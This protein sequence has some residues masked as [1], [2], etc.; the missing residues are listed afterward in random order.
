M[1]ADSLTELS[2]NGRVLVTPCFGR[3]SQLRRSCA[4]ASIQTGVNDARRVCRRQ[5]IH[6]ESLGTGQETSREDKEGTL[7]MHLVGGFWFGTVTDRIGR[8]KSCCDLYRGVHLN[9]RKSS[10]FIAVIE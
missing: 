9:A 10:F 5:N 2:S 6:S 3:A 4:G 1:W 8:M 7:E